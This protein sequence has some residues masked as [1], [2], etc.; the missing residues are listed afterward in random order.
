MKYTVN[1]IKNVYHFA[2]C[3][4]EKKNDNHNILK[5][6]KTTII[7]KFSMTFNQVLSTAAASSSVYRDYLIGSFQPD[8]INAKDQQ[9]LETRRID[10]IHSSPNCSKVTLKRCFW[11]SNKM[12]VLNFHVLLCIYSNCGEKWQGSCE[13]QRISLA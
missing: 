10:A 13:N 5:L 3:V 12:D 4:T 7:S 9:L 11:V 1:S 8:R 2:T 6:I